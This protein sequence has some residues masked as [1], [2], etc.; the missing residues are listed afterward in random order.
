MIQLYLL[1]YGILGLNV[2]VVNV[3]EMVHATVPRRSLL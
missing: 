3:L 2:Y 1:I